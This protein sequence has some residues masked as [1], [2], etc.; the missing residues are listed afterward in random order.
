MGQMSNSVQHLLR[1]FA[2]TAYPGQPITFE[3]MISAFIHTLVHG[4]PEVYV[5]KSLAQLDRFARSPTM[6][7][8]HLSDCYDT[9]LDLCRRLRVRPHL[10]PRLLVDTFLSHLPSSLRRRVEFLAGAD[11]AHI[12]DEIHRF[13]RLVQQAEALHA[14]FS[15]SRDISPARPASP[16]ED[17]RRRSAPPLQHSTT[18]NNTPPRPLR[19]PGGARDFRGLP[20]R[21]RDTFAG[22]SHPN[23]LPLASHPGIHHL[24]QH[25]IAN[26]HIAPRPY[27]APPPAPALQPAAPTQPC[28]FCRAQGHA[29]GT[30][31]AY[32]EWRL[33]DPAR[34]RLCPAC[35]SSIRCPPDCFRRL[36]YARATTP[37][38]NLTAMAVATLFERM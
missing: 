38:L 17:P 26:P 10:D 23:S 33:Q 21:G 2:R 6:L 8:V 15:R 28:F 27:L 22:R 34:A 30:C 9:Y 35:R 32:R 11:W 13:A 16:N 20:P 12:R 31:Q 18:Y 37:I 4:D 1:Q 36:S 14:A 19:P 25:P 29:L 5:R 7:H 3:N 24:Q